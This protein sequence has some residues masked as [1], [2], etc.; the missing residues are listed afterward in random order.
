MAY[1]CR[2]VSDG[3]M[4]SELKM[5]WVKIFETFRDLILSCKCVLCSIMRM[6]VEGAS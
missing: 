1:Y 2:T 5:R 4:C 3:E 6:L